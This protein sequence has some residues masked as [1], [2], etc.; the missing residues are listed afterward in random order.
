MMYLPVRSL[1]SIEIAG[2]DVGVEDLDGGEVGQI[3][4]QVVDQGDQ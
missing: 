4:A 1:G 3:R 2:L